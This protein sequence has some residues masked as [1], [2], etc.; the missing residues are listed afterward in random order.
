MRKITF[1]NDAEPPLSAENLNQLQE[2]I[3]D[4]IEESEDNLQT[5]IDAL[6]E[7]NAKYK[8]QIPTGHKKT[9]SVQL[10]DSAGGLAIENVA[11]WGG[12]SQETYEGKNMLSYESKSVTQN[13]LS[14]NAEKNGVIS[15]KGTTTATINVGIDLEPIKV[16][17][18]YKLSGYT[19]NDNYVQLYY[20]DVNGTLKYKAFKDSPT[21][22]FEEGDTLYQIFVYINAVG[23][24]LNEK[25]YLQL[26]KGITATSY[27]PY[28]G[29]QASPNP[30]YPQAIHCVTGNCNAKMHNKNFFNKTSVTFTAG[31][32]LNVD[33]GELRD[34]SSYEWATSDFVAIQKTKNAVIQGKLVNGNWTETICWYDE[35]QNYIGGATYTNT[36]TNNVYHITSNVDFCYVRFTK[37]SSYY[38]ADTVQ[39]EI[40]TTATSYK[41]FAENLYDSSTITTGKYLTQNGQPTSISNWNTT[42]YIPVKALGIYTY[43]GLTAVGTA[44]Y[45]CYYDSNKTFVSS[46]KQAVGENTITIPENISYVRFSIASADINTFSLVKENQAPLTLGNIELYDGDK[47]TIEYTE[48]AG[49]KKVTGANVVK[50]FKKYVF[51]GNENYT[52]SSLSDE[53][54]FCGYCTDDMSRLNMLEGTNMKAS[55]FSQIGHYG[56]IK[57]KDCIN[58]TKQFHVRIGAQYL[59]ENSVIGFKK[60]LKKWYDAGEPL[61]VVYKL[62][63]PETTSITDT[64][65]LAQLET[66]INMKTYKEI[67]NIETEGA[68]LNPVL[69]FDYSKDLTTIINELQQAVLNS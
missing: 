56:T 57:D 54:W 68:D 9:D 12:M 44:P 58:Y 39:L 24:T 10:T 66:L 14:I 40:G 41:D 64:T 37:H 52:K 27:E 32:G 2:N 65:L 17:G 20:K 30:D 19:R 42:D 48:Q 5:Q 33:T 53:N 69:E 7:E 67:T 34:A 4:G 60:L 6:V 35:N 15:L 23:T 63:T 59:E 3:E 22:N 26:E 31:K 43:S 46:F 50:K 29:G 51:T 38:D 8:A 11:V 49:Y 55:R 62:A 45:S 36:N 18:E 1:I 61:S 28:C 47:I 16:V 21:I 25:L 13:G